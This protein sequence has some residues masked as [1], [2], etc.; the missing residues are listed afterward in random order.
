VHYELID[1]RVVM[2]SDLVDE[3]LADVAKGVR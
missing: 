3:L 2:L 1:M